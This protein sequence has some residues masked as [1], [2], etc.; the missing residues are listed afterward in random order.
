MRILLSH[1]ASRRQSA[2]PDRIDLNL[3]WS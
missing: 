1:R 2:A 3:D